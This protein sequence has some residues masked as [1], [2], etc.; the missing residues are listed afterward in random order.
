MSREI[1]AGEM[2]HRHQL[3]TRYRN[4]QQINDYEDRI[5][6]IRQSINILI[7]EE[8]HLLEE[9][10]KLKPARQTSGRGGA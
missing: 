4:Q 7:R 9:I 6:G 8:K 1:P 2:D 5:R 10:K 3:S